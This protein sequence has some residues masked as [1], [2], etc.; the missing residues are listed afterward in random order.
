MH[1]LSIATE[2]VRACRSELAARGGGRLVGVAV[3][4]GELSAVE[5][6]LLRYA[7]EAVVAASPDA[8]A[9]LEVEPVAARQSCT[10]CGE[11]RERQ[12]G[13]W[14][15]LCPLCGGPLRVDGGDELEI[16][17]L[18]IEEQVAAEDSSR[19]ATTPA[20]RRDLVS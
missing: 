1:E 3:R 12:P 13:S 18:V 19:P 5:P 17:E 10:D 16:A 14:L 4:V 20:S 11:I 9:R 15:R 8:G 7:F 2:L 6:D